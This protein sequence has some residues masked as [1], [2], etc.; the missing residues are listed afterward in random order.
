MTLF[1]DRNSDAHMDHDLALYAQDSW[2]MQ[3]LTLNL[4]LR[5]DWITQSRRRSRPPG[6][7]ACS[8]AY[9]LAGAS[10]VRRTGR[11]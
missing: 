9:R 10:T 4:G 5:F 7:R 8:R 11:I 1:A 6:Q 2:T 3:R